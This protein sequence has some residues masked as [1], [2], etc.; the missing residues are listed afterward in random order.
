MNRRL[1]PHLCAV[2]VG[3]SSWMLSPASFGQ[4]SADARPFVEFELGAER[5]DNITRVASD[6]LSDTMG[7]A[8]LAFG[9]EQHRPKLE[10]LIAADL[11]YRHYKDDTYD[12]EILGGLSADL[13]WSIL[14][15]RFIWIVEETYGQIAGNLQQPDTP[16][17]REDFNYFTTGPDLRI[18]LGGRTFA[19]LSGRW[20]DVY[21]EES[22]QGSENVEGS[23]ALARQL[24][25]QSTLSLNASVED[26]RY[27]E[28]EFLEDDRITEGF[29]QLEFLGGRTTISADAGY[30]KA[31]R[32]DES[33]DGPLARLNLSREVTSRTTL[34]LDAGYE[35]ADAATAFR[36]DQ[37]A[38]GL[39]EDV[40]N[41]VASQDVFRTTYAYLGL[42]T[43][44]ERT[45][46][47]VV[48]FGL[49]ERHET[50]TLLDRDSF[51]LN[52]NWSRRLSSR[53]DLLVRAAYTND[54]FINA[55]FPYDEWLAGLEIGW[56]LTSFVSMRISV[57][58]Y[59]GSS[60]NALRDYEENRAYVGF[61]YA[62]GQPA[63]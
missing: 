40:R 49:K 36:L 7:I 47:D 35:F 37:D 10:S 43:R 16:D 1:R 13:A 29:L 39:G 45:T 34:R 14:P 26:I 3:C 21:Y 23:A 63:R 9:L 53:L 62:R 12:D 57:D 15:E 18:P 55:N 25:E 48:L 6:E 31:E 41:A 24:S 38:I 51:G 46:F 33:S 4:S 60:D 28:E 30:T 5:S 52:L 2:A 42:N 58:H 17:N 32:G 44:R 20:S 54:D 22:D 61:R 59:E 11:Q 56:R 27:D 50:D 8:R 19:E